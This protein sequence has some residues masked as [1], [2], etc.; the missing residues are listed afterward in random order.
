MKKKE[1]II[2]KA[3]AAV[4]RPKHSNRVHQIQT[5]KLTSRESKA[6]AI[7][8]EEIGDNYA[9]HNYPLDAPKPGQ[10]QYQHKGYV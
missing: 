6:V 1:P 4:K 7:R 2:P 8:D 3:I 5:R 10:I 9:N